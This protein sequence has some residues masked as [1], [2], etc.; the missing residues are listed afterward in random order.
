[1]NPQD[2]VFIMDSSIG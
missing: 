2:I 1:V